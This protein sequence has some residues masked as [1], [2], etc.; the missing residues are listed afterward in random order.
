MT[1]PLGRNAPRNV[2]ERVWYYLNHASVDLMVEVKA[3][4][5]THLATTKTR[6]TKRVLTQML[7]ELK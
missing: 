4:N 2:N 1:K 6:L 3:T 5:G 7:A